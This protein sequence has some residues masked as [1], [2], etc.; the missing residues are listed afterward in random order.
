MRQQNLHL[1]FA[2][3][4]LVAY[5][6][7]GFVGL[8]EVVLCFG[9]D[10]HIALERTTGG[11]DC[12]IPKATAMPRPT[13]DRP[14]LAQSVLSPL[15]WLNAEVSP[16]D[17]CGPCVDVN[18]RPGDATSIRPPIAQD[19]TPLPI[20]FPLPAPAFFSR[21]PLL[22]VGRPLASSLPDAGDNPS[23]QHSVILRI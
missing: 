5:L 2:Y 7:T 12:E 9:E 3:L 15:V 11:G 19:L 10:G 22:P 20:S 17:H 21:L 4:T 13:L 18:L 8:Q 6:A 16:T 23:A 14:T 1:A